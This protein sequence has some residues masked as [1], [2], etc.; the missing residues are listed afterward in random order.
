MAIRWLT[1]GEPFPHPEEAHESGLLA[2]GGDLRAERLLAAY[3]RGIFPWPHEG[4]PLLWFSPDPRF[5]LRACELHVPRTLLRR[6]RRGEFEIRLDT[7]FRRVVE[8]C[9]AAPRK[10][11][12]GTWI[13]PEMV[14]AYETLHRLGYAH[15][16]EAWRDGELVGGLYGVSLGAVFTGESMFA[17]APDASKAALATLVR[18]LEV[19]G[20]G[21]LDAQTPSSHLAAFGASCWPRALYLAAL[22]R[23]ME[24]P[25]RRG[26]WRIDSRF[27]W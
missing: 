2:A 7:A 4:L 6:L 22:A 20:I 21:L 16:A 8:G 25:T 24:M 17:L 1:D 27:R 13:T 15:S 3:S 10:P 14:D 19:W 5:V 23:A 11:D 12:L 18:Q 26:R 9:A